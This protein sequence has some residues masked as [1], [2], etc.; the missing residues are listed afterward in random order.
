MATPSPPAIEAQELVK[1]FGSFVAVD[2]VSLRIPQGEVYGLLGPNGAGK[3]TFLRM[4]S[5]LLRPTAGHASLAGIDVGA[6]PDEVKRHLGYMSQRFSLYGD[7]KVREN[8]EL[9]GALYGL[10]GARLRERIAWAVETTQLAARLA[11][12]ASEL[13]GGFRQRLA[14][15]CALL[16]E[17][18]VVILDEPTG[19]VDPVMRRSFFSLIDT[20]SRSGVTVLL[21]THFLDEAEY[22]HRVGLISSAR[23]IAEGAPSELK[24]RLS[25]RVLLEVRTDEPRRALTALRARG[26]GL[27]LSVFGAGVHVMA[28]PGL[29]ESDAVERV[30]GA[31]R[32]A[33]LATHPV[34]IAP[35]LEDVFLQ[36]TRTRGG[37]T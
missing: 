30:S 13:P 4:L 21:T 8:L 2:R 10:A 6:E 32:D 33:G 14:L 25:H 1:R 31:L 9:F 7:L 5:G 22:C 24:A 20:L 23:L 17:P 19:G 29:T 34:R 16:H 37:E 18:E 12:R 3:S 26:E 27:E 35:T 28:P 36:L 11:S 15:G